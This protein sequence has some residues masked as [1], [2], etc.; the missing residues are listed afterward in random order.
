MGLLYSIINIRRVE[1]PGGQQKSVSS[2]QY[3]REV[4][5]VLCSAK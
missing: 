2:Y 5:G 1:T 4:F 3:E